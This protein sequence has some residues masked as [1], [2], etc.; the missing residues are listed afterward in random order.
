MFAKIE[1][2]HRTAIGRNRATA[3][4]SIGAQQDRARIFHC[5]D[6]LEAKQSRAIRSAFFDGLTY[7]QLAEHMKVPLGT[8]KSWVRRG[9][10]QL[11]ECL[12]N[13]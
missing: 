3:E 1:I 4:E 13:G 12:G 11:R 2:R 6:G 10:L 9:L 5:L 7:V 8:R